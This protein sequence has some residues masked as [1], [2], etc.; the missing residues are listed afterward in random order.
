MAQVAENLLCKS[1]AVSSNPSEN[2]KKKKDCVCYLDQ[3]VYQL[4]HSVS[5]IRLFK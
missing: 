5:W 2:D 1:K 3:I 4:N